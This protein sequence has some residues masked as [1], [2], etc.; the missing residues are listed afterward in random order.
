VADDVGELL[1]ISFSYHE[2]AVKTGADMNGAALCVAVFS[3][4]ASCTSQSQ[5]R[6]PLATRA[7]DLAASHP[8]MTCSQEPFGIST[9]AP[10][11]MNVCRTQTNGH[12]AIVLDS[13]RTVWAVIT[14]ISKRTPAEAASAFD[15]IGSQL[16]R[17][18][19][20]LDSA[21][22]VLDASQGRVY[23]STYG[24]LLLSSGLDSVGTG[25]VLGEYLGI[26]PCQGR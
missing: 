5:Y 26:P 23:R 21:C 12:V 1:A 6:G 4:L 8:A 9:A 7:A 18:G 17:N 19:L 3:A 14:T 2:A 11:P 13:N 10:F 22:R 25:L 16:E 15:S 24:Y 20:V